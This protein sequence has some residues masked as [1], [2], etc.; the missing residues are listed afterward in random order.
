MAVPALLMC[1]GN[2]VAAV[3]IYISNSTP[4]LCRRRYKSLS[5]TVQKVRHFADG[6]GRVT[7]IL[8]F[9]H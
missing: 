7:V 3:R 5:V 1:C 4:F 8:F 6:E 2:S 9:F